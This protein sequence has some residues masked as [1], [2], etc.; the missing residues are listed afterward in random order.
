MWLLVKLH[1]DAMGRGDEL[2]VEGNE[3]L[4]GALVDPL[5]DAISCRLLEPVDKGGVVDGDFEDLSAGA[6]CGFGDG[7]VGTAGGRKG[8]VVHDCERRT[9]ICCCFTLSI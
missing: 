6:R 4:D 5:A 7:V 1:N 8:L 9:D 2:T 3:E